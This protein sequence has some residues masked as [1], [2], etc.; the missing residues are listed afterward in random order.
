MYL[1]FLFASCID[2]DVLCHFVVRAASGISALCYLSPFLLLYRS[3]VCI[4]FSSW[5]YL[6]FFEDLFPS[7][8]IFLFLKVSFLVSLRVSSLL[9]D[10]GKEAVE[11]CSWWVPCCWRACAGAMTC[12]FACWLEW[13]IGDLIHWLLEGLRG[14]GFTPALFDG[15][16]GGAVFPWHPLFYRI[17]LLVHSRWH[18]IL[19]RAGW[20]W[21]WACYLFVGRLTLVA[22]ACNQSQGSFFCFC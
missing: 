1:P 11:C 16:L 8:G 20:F 21:W 9:E 6:F 7:W 19:V 3:M 15:L 17:I 5:G 18:L 14:C 10:E 12:S 4:L 13:L 22:V 2:S